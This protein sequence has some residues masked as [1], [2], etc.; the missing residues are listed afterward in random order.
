[1][2]H[3]DLIKMTV[4]INTL[5]LSTQIIVK[6]NL[7]VTHLLLVPVPRHYPPNDVGVHLGEDKRSVVFDSQ[8]SLLDGLNW[9]WATAVLT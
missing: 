8:V 5:Q 9:T 6:V 7:V 4:V 1:M 3:F 2:V